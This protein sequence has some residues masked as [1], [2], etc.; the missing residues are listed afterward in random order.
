MTQRLAAGGGRISA[1]PTFSPFIPTTTSVRGDPFGVAMEYMTAAPTP[2]VS[3]PMQPSPVEE[4][5]RLPGF[6]GLDS[7]QDFFGGG[8]VGPNGANTQGMSPA[9]LGQFGQVATALGQFGFNPS[10][11]GPLGFMLGLGAT[12]A[13]A[14]SP[15]AAIAPFG[16][17]AL[18]MAVPGPVGSVLGQGL[19]G[20]AQGRSP[21]EIGKSIAVNAALAAINP[22]AP[23]AFSIAKSLFGTSPTSNL[24]Q[25]ANLGAVGNTDASLGAPIGVGIG[26]ITGISPN[27]A[28]IGLAPPSNFGPSFGS[29]S[30]GNP[31]FAG[32]F[33]DPGFGGTGFSGFG[34]SSGGG[35]GGFGTGV[36][37]G[38]AGGIGSSAS[39]SDGFGMGTG[40][41]SAGGIGGIGSAATGFGAI[42][43]SGS[44]SSGAGGGGGD[45]GGDMGIGGATGVGATASTSANL[46]DSIGVS[47]GGLGLGLGG[48]QTGVSG[49]GFAA[50]I[51]SGGGGGGGSAS[52]GD[53]GFGFGGVSAGD[54]GNLGFGGGSL[55]GMASEG[56]GASSGGGGGGGGKIICTLLYEKG[57]MPKEIYQADQNFGALLALSDPAA[58]AGYYRWAKH[59]VSWMEQDTVW[60]KF[61]TAVTRR[62][63][64]PWAYA[65]AAE[66]GVPVR[67][68]LFG[69]ALLH[70]GLPFCRFVSPAKQGGYVNG[71]S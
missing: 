16:A 42:G 34:G 46:G 20:V 32:T 69:R 35:D 7:S 38:G 22:V 29:A 8:D 58:Y 44:S 51:G 33:G 3:A 41:G 13:S 30:I 70:V 65:M 40:V 10:F 21:A 28:P 11:M 54:T 26:G 48:G 49:S 52:A 66:M 14:Q 68:S 64:M 37:M 63:A 27:A 5:P 24:G 4:L 50:N 45:G 59:V 53:G 9:T 25:A 2:P 1:A 31:G 19:L 6:D 57:Y 17:A 47:T 15:Q 23:L 55:G 67:S 43:D 61:V 71:L 60:S 62:I 56:G 18:S 12:A 39:A 36:G